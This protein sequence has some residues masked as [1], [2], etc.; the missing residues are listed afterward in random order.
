[1]CLH[2]LVREIVNPGYV[3]EQEVLKIIPFL[4]HDK[5]KSNRLLLC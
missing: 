1:M 2:M 4:T 3:V 5:D